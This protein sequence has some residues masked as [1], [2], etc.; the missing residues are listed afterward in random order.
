MLIKKSKQNVR[1][2][3]GRQT[4][5][6]RNIFT[7]VCIAIG[8]PHLCCSIRFLLPVSTMLWQKCKKYIKGQQTEEFGSSFSLSDCFV[9]INS[10]PEKV[11]T[12]D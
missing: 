4:D 1:N 7:P 9:L 5:Q 3:Q 10:Q 11:L 2:Y 12:A 8:C 6:Y